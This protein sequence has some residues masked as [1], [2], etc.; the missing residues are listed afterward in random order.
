MDSEPTL[1]RVQS[2]TFL[3]SFG[4]VRDW[5]RTLNGPVHLPATLH[6]TDLLLI[7]FKSRGRGGPVVNF[8]ALVTC[9]AKSLYNQVSEFRVNRVLGGEVLFSSSSVEYFHCYLLDCKPHF[10]GW[11][12]ANRNSSPCTGEEWMQLFS[13]LATYLAVAS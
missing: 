9:L 11:A 3:L 6:F 5:S 8:P 2:T 12:G 7:N 4:H 13:N 1:W 10:E